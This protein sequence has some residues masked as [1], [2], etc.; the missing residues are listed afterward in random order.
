[1]A[2]N[3]AE[4]HKQIFTDVKKKHLKLSA[5]MVKSTELRRFL[6]RQVHAKKC[7]FNQDTEKFVVP[8]GT[9]LEKIYD[10]IFFL[11]KEELNWAV[12]TYPTFFKS[13]LEEAM[14]LEHRLKT[15]LFYWPRDD[16]FVEVYYNLDNQEELAAT[17]LEEQAKT[18]KKWV[19]D[20]CPEFTKRDKEI[21]LAYAIEF[22]NL[23]R[24][25]VSAM[26]VVDSKGRR[27]NLDAQSAKEILS[28]T[29]KSFFACETER[30]RIVDCFF[31]VQHLFK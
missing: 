10:A 19:L 3:E 20:D 17:V 9:D 13:T 12:D 23:L 7:T 29:D 24:E 25:L 2:A 14:L 28:P 6:L 18:D 21:I 8:V 15:G 26:F 1:M 11:G 27:A 22:L 5:K 4:K 16:D 31:E 30:Q